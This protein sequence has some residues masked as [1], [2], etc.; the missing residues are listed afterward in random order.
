MKYKYFK[1]ILYV[2]IFFGLLIGCSEN[3]EKSKS[4]DSP[5]DNQTSDS[6]LNVAFSAEPNTLDPLISTSRLENY[7]NDNIFE[8]L[9]TRNSKGEPTL[10]LAKSIDSSDDNK[11]HTFHLRENIKFHNGEEMTSDDV[12]ASMNRWAK[13]SKKI[14]DLYP[15]TTFKVKDKYTVTMEVVDYKNDFWDVLVDASQ[16]GAI[17]PKHIVEDADERGIKEYI[18]TGPYEFVEHKQGQHIHI[19]KYENYQPLDTPSDGHAGEKVATIDDMFFHFVT[20]PSTRVAGIKTGEYD[21]AIQIPLV[22][23]D[24]LN[25]DPNINLYTPL[26]GDLMFFYNKKKG[27][28]KD[29]KMRKAIHTAINHEEIME[30]AFSNEELYKIHPSFMNPDVEQWATSAGE[31]GYNQ[32]DIEKAKKLLNEAGYNGETIEIIAAK[33]HPQYWDPAVVL[34][35]QLSNIGVNVKLTNYDWATYLSKI[36]SP[37]NFD[38]AVSGASYLTTPSQ[39]LV[40]NANFAG[41]SDHPKID[42][43]VDKMGS[44]D[45]H[46]EAYKYWEE[47]QEFLIMEY[48]PATKVGGYTSLTITTDKVKEFNAYPSPIQPTFWDI[49]LE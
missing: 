8:A 45:D 18:G 41:W 11:T 7:I 21:M 26:D 10:Q 19:K 36:E 6:T 40:I 38:I 31:E 14:L 30:A 39:L 29:V 23:Y 12:V 47:L 22:M 33:D 16:Y 32:N 35:E 44:A 28:L 4:E 5:A 49:R 2:L 42:E 37:D 27:W 46:D 3:V 25:E 20:D 17:M 43:L 9:M 48:V 13:S 1:R 24:E 34:Q 15:D